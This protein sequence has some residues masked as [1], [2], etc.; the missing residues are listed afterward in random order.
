MLYIDTNE[1]SFY[2]DDILN[3]QRT[4]QKFVDEIKSI[5]QLVYSKHNMDD[6][7]AF[8]VQHLIEEGD[9]FVCY[10]SKLSAALYQTTF[11]ASKMIT[12]T[13]QLMNNYLDISH[14]MIGDNINILLND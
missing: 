12:E 5:K 9:K 6:G 14:S 8:K 11:D 4:A 13:N 2:I 10:C 3:E 7:L 1:L